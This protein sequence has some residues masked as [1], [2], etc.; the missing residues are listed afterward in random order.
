MTSRHPF[1][2]MWK[3]NPLSF[4]TGLYERSEAKAPLTTSTRYMIDKLALSLGKS[5]KQFFKQFD[6][7]ERAQM[8]A[9]YQTQNEIVW[10]QVEYPL[11]R[12]RK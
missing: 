5:E 9:T 6:D 1:Q 12:P 11:R 10:V 2:V 8:L 4:Y 7:L 3:G